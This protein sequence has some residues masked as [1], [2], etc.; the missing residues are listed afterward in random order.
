MPFP[1]ETQS[2]L[3]EAEGAGATTQGGTTSNKN[4]VAA[5]LECW[6]EAAGAE[7]LVSAAEGPM[8]VTGHSVDSSFLILRRNE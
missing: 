4:L 1:R 2:S 5:W 8:A 3:L 7:S 6:L